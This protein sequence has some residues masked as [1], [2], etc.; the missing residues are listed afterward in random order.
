MVLF[1]ANII[2]VF[3]KPSK[4]IKVAKNFYEKKKKKITVIRS[5]LFHVFIPSPISWT[6]EFFCEQ[7]RAHNL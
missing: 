2:S 4:Q 1:L 6:K 3:R 5:Q 7:N